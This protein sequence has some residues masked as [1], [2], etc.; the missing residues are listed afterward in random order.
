MKTFDE[1][2]N[3]EVDELNELVQDFSKLNCD[4]EEEKRV[5]KEAR[6]KECEEKHKIKKFDVS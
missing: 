6:R 1:I 3:A 2:R 5:R 4:A